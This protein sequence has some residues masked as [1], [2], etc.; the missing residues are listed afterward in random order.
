MCVDAGRMHHVSRSSMTGNLS[1][2]ETAQK[3][4]PVNALETCRGYT[5]VVA[6]S[7]DFESIRQCRPTDATTNP[8]LALKAAE[9][10]E[11]VHLASRASAMPATPGLELGR[12]V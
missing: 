7:G 8:T 4:Q 6:D 9:N 11:P 10:R 1:M 3:Q 5:T 2:A 12:R